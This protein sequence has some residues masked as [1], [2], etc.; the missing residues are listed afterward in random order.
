MSDADCQ[1]ASKLHTKTVITKTSE[2]FAKFQPVTQPPAGSWKPTKPTGTNT[3]PLQT[4][5]LCFPD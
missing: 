5:F 2:L 1:A 4:S 3:S